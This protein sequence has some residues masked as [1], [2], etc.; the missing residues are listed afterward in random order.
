MVGDQRMSSRLAKYR[1]PFANTRRV[2]R[3]QGIVFLQELK[4]IDSWLNWRYEIKLEGT[5]DSAFLKLNKTPYNSHARGRVAVNRPDTWSTFEQA[6]A[7]YETGKYDGV[8][9]VQS[10]TV[11]VDP[12]QQRRPVRPADVG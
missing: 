9:L 4:S 2:G 1:V 10:H 5:S 6:R 3:D 7:A 8:G 11:G 12:R